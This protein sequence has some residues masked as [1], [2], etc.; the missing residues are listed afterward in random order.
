M[1]SVIIPAY[2]AAEYIRRSVENAVSKNTEV[3]IVENGSTDQTTEV[4]QKITEEHDNVFLYH[5]EKGV[6]NARN[7][8]IEKAKGEWIAF[9][10]ADDY[11]TDQGLKTLINDA[12]ENALQNSSDNT[13]DLYVYGHEAGT[14]PHPVIDKTLTETDVEK[15]RA[16]MISNPTKYMQ[17]WAKLFKK[18]IIDEHNLRFDTAMSLSEDSDFTLRYSRY[19]KCIA[20]SETIAYH[21]TIDNVSTM[22]AKANGDKVPRFIEAMKTTRKAVE[23]ETETIRHAFSKY[24]LMNLNISMVRDIYSVTSQVKKSDRSKILKNTVKEPVFKEAIKSVKLKECLSPRMI[25]VLAMKLGFYKGAGLV[26]SIRAKQNF[27]REH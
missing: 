9:V 17:A 2:N 8:G 20:I 4:A 23:D 15:C 24:A 3:I 13:P 14:T 16:M 18:S 11:L 7:L 25:P 26:Y 5:S 21:Y 19:A 10:D 27:K 1:I 12:S 22:R 6:S